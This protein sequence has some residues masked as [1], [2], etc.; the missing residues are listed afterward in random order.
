VGEQER[1][2]KEIAG[3]ERKGGEGTEAENSEGVLGTG[4][5]RKEEQRFQENHVCPEECSLKQK[6]EQA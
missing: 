5:V 6:E 4:G 3:L 1:T 2:N